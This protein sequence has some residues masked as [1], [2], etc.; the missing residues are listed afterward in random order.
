MRLDQTCGDSDVHHAQMPKIFFRLEMG[1]LTRLCVLWGPAKDLSVLVLVPFLN[2]AARALQGRRRGTRASLLARLS[3]PLP[4]VA[5][6]VRHV[7]RT[8]KNAPEARREK[9][10]QKL[11][12]VASS[13]HPSLNY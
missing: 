4:V 1:L 10:T 8:L 11:R 9:R 6:V 12:L 2:H 7:L 13:P 5:H 3:A